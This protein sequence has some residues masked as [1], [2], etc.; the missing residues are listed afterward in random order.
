M[1]VISC[2]EFAEIVRVFASVPLIILKTSNGLSWK[3]TR[4]SSPRDWQLAA[5]EMR[6][7]K[8]SCYT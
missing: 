6:R 8:T 1:L 2:N 3:R 4:G 7:P 5:C